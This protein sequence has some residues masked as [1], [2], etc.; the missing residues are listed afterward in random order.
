VTVIPLH[1]ELTTH[2]MAALLHVSSPF[3]IK[4]LDARQ[5]PCRKVGGHRHIRKEKSPRS[6]PIDKKR[7]EYVSRRGEI[8]RRVRLLGGDPV[9]TGRAGRKG[10]I[11]V[12]IEPRV[13]FQPVPFHLDDVDLVVAFVVHLS[14]IVLIQEVVGHHQPFAI[15]REVYV[16]RPAPAPNSTTLR[17]IGCDRSE[18]SSMTT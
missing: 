6:L 12:Q 9:R 5:I 3:L 14:E 1:A 13:Q 17:S 11:E 4:G 15:F 2:Q 7:G 10:G 18:T 8:K 16:V